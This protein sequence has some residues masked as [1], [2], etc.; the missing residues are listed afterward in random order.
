MHT[1]NLKNLTPRHRLMMESLVIDG[2][3]PREVRERFDISEPRLS[4]IRK[5]P[6]WRQQE[7]E[8]RDSMRA[9]HKSRMERL[10]PKALDAL[11]DVVQPSAIF[12]KD[13]PHEIRVVNRPQDRIS[14]AREILSRSGIESVE[15]LKLEGSVDDLYSTLEEIKRRKAEIRLEMERAGVPLEEVDS[16]H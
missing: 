12:E 13:T 6:L 9:D 1:S 10:V 14:A 8:L 7:H 16:V 5:S 2:L 15:R 3:T 11:E 4:I